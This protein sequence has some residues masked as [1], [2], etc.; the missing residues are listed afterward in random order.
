[1]FMKGY[2]QG[3]ADPDPDPCYFAQKDPDPDPLKSTD[4]YESGFV[5]FW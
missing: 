5:R 4:P 2:N 1:M 3:C